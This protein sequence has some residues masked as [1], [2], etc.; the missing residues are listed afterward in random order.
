MGNLGWM[1]SVAKKVGGP[2]VMLLIVA[3]GGCWIPPGRYLSPSSSI[4]KSE[5][6]FKKLLD[7]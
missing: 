5:T 3:A 7:T 2:K 6:D 1:T 4:S